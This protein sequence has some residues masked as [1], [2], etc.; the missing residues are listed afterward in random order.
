MLGAPDGAPIFLGDRLG[1]APRQMPCSRARSCRSRA[2]VRR[3]GCRPAPR[4]L[5]LSVGHRWSREV[6]PDTAAPWMP[7]TRRWPCSLGPRA[8]WRTQSCVTSDCPKQWL[9]H[10][11]R[12]VRLATR[13][14][15]AAALC[16]DRD[17]RAENQ[18]TKITRARL[19]SSTVAPWIAGQWGQGGI[20]GCRDDAWRQELFLHRAEKS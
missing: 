5:P 15:I 17:D 20:T 7:A 9:S 8:I 12:C 16:P 14:K 4:T 2:C 3:D 10:W 6:A 19:T 11:L 18:E 13:L 1:S